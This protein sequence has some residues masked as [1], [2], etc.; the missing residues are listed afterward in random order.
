MVNLSD[1]F[2]NNENRLKMPYI[3]KITKKAKNYFFPQKIEISWKVTIL[4]G[5][6]L[7]LVTMMLL[8]LFCKKIYFL[9]CLSS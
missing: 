1:Y 9:F 3:C 7:R 2:M 8:A 6:I 5:T 4:G